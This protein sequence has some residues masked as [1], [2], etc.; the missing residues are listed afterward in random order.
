MKGQVFEVKGRDALKCRV[1]SNGS[2]P[3]LVVPLEI[4]KNVTARY[5]I[6]DIS[7]GGVFVSVEPDNNT[8]GEAV[9]A[10]S[11]QRFAWKIEVAKGYQDYFK[12]KKKKAEYEDIPES[13]SEGQLKAAIRNNV[14]RIKP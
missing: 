12:P 6:Q 1:E 2:I 7:A 10:N 4:C 3:C 14:E 13:M 5:Q 8:G 9:I 11:T